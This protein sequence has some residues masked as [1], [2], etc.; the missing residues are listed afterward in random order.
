MYGEV[1]EVVIADREI[2]QP[3]LGRI[4]TQ[5]EFAAITAE[6]GRDPFHLE[7]RV[8]QAIEAQSPRWRIPTRSS[9][10]GVRLSSAEEYSGP[11]MPRN[12]E[13]A[14]RFPFVASRIIR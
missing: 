5:E 12:L 6:E 14:T 11:P 8:D 1:D 9:T 4:G 2:L 3:P 7:S 10:L 13:G